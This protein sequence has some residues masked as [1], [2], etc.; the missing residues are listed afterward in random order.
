MFGFNSWLLLL[1]Y[2]DNLTP[3]R[4]PEID[5]IGKDKLMMNNKGLNNGNIGDYWL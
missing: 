4:R 3:F 2:S 5:P 1:E